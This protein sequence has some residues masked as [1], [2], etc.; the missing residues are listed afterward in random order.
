MTEHQTPARD[1]QGEQHPLLAFA[2]LMRVLR[3]G[4]SWKQAQTHTSL[5]RFLLE[6]AYEVLEAIDECEESGDF[7]HLREELGDLLLQ[8]YFHAVIAEE[9]GEF[10]LADVARDVDAKMRRRNPHVIGPD[11]RPGLTPDEVNELWQRAKAAEKAAAATARQE[12]PG[13]GEGTPSPAADVTAELP[14]LMWCS[15]VLGRA[16]RAGT[17][18]DLSG[19]DSPDARLGDRLLALVAEARAAGLDAEQELRGAVRSRL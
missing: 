3:D 9:R 5:K 18:L 7:S 15:K 14:A 19:T 6:E 8:V 10:T 12:V 17:P 16:E 13:A 4:C 2:D 11:A 1:A